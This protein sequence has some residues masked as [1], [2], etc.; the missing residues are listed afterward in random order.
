MGER[1]ISLRPGAKMPFVGE[2]YGLT[3][4]A[5]DKLSLSIAMNT[6]EKQTIPREFMAGSSIKLAKLLI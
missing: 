6:H 1:V 5:Y 2:Q 3:I 4:P